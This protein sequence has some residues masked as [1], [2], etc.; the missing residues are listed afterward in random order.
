MRTTL[1]LD[2]DVAKLLEQETHRQRRPFKHVVNDAIRRGLAP[3]TRPRQT[4]PYRVTPHHAQLLP[5]LDRAALNRLAD[6]IENDAVVAQAS[7]R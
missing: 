3:Q 4:A 6:E 7:R 2:P 5:G 1:T